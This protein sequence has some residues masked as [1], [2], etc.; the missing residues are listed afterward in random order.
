[1]RFL[2]V[3]LDLRDRHCVV[4]GGGTVGTRKVRK[5][6][7]VGARVT[8]ISP[9]VT[10]EIQA[11]VD[12]GRLRWIEGPFEPEHLNSAC[13]VIVA[14]DAPGVNER[15]AAVARDC[16][17]LLCDA[18][19]GERSDVIFGAVHEEDGLT[20]ATFSDGR[21][22]ARSKDARD[23]IAAWLEATD[24]HGREPP[25]DDVLLVLVAHGSRDPEWGRPLEELTAN[26][27]ETLGTENVRLAYSQFT[28]P[29]LE[30]V[31][32]GAG[33]EIRRVRVL[34]LFM[35]AH[36]HV[37]RDIRPAVD[38]LRRAHESLEVELLPPVGEL[39]SFRILLAELAREVTR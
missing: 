18:T 38:A 7:E 34:P 21:D 37:E 27:A 36:G 17:T 24:G 6:L 14:T 4:V 20:V 31:V 23:R 35:T 16:S 10:A 12:A 26:L 9:A 28:S 19:S 13:L 3:G 2:P 29:P 33:P 25:S 15:L 5:L 30:D 1:M 8:V 11:E 22:P 32:A 39:P